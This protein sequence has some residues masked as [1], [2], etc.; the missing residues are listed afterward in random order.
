MNRTI[1]AAGVALAMALG[2]APS[3]ASTVFVADEAGKSITAIEVE[4]GRSERLPIPIA[5]HNVD[6]T[7]DGRTLLAVG[8]GDD[9]GHVHS[10][11][12][13]KEA[14]GQLLLIEATPGTGMR[15]AA[16]V[17]IGGHPAHVVPAPDGGRAFVTDAETNAVIVV[18]LSER[19]VAARVKV[20]AYPHGLRVSP[21]GRTIAVA[22]MKGDSVSLIDTADPTRVATV[23]V[24][25][26][27]VQVGFDP[28]GQTLFVSL[29][30]EDKVAAVDLSTKTV[31]GTYP[32]GDGPVQ[33]SVSPD[34]SKLLVAN[35]GRASNPDRTVS[36]LDAR[37]GSP[38]ATVEVGSGAHGITISRDGRNA[39]VTN[40]Y[41]ASVS[42][43]DL[44]SLK[45][46]AKHATGKGPNGVAVR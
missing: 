28:T 40:T 32:V 41:E 10:A 20:G 37:T 33:L 9:H 16:S 34:G 12:N 46:V 11:S 3:R 45:E 25:K 35:Q 26:A 38:I 42:V 17:D 4:T 29:N 14:G 1:L 21:D 2:A 18:N 30:G 7:P 31:K 5:P 44:D 24:G 36:V 15:V 39:F 27:P 43:I 8:M 19:R 23:K 13:S 6:L 22:N